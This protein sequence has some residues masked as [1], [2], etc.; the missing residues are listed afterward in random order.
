ML[1]LTRKLGETVHIGRDIT[2]T[3]LQIRGQVMKIGIDAP[4]SIRVLRGE[5]HSAD[6]AAGRLANMVLS[7]IGQ[8]VG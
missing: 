1:V 2:V 8:P 4:A 7:G 6:C 5:L 3:C